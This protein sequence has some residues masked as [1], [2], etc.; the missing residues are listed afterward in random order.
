MHRQRTLVRGFG[1]TLVELLV[2]IAIIALLMAILLPA[3][4]R[5][6][7]QAKRIVC[8]SDLR[9]LTLGWTAYASGNNDKIVNGAPVTLV[10]CPSCPAPATSDK[11]GASPP[12][13]TATITEQADHKDEVPWIGGYNIATASDCG[14]KCAIDSGALWRYIKDYKLYHCP[15]G[16]KGETITYSIVDGVNGR[17]EGRGSSRQPYGKKLSAR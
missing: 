3:L 7:T 11:C 12:D 4:S 6:R 8:L 10:Q 16:M 14:K 15:T 2:V 17:K 1:F 13:T 5:A 9:Q